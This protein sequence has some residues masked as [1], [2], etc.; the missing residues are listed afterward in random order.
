MDLTIVPLPVPA[1][2]NYTAGM[3]LFPCYA[4][5]GVRFDDNSID[6]G[7]G[8]DCFSP[9]AHTN[10]TDIDVTAQRNRLLLV[11]AMD[12]FGFTNLSTEWW[13]YTLRDEPF[14][15]TYFNFPV[16]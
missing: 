15:N 6:M 4:P 10:N 13:H 8:F 9:L 16:V 11:H 5:I 3:K 14:P 12:L 1:E 7:T 2:E